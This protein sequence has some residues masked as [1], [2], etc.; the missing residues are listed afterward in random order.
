MAI[1]NSENMRAFDERF[2]C[3]GSVRGNPKTASETASRRPNSTPQNRGVSD[4]AQVAGT[5]AAGAFAVLRI[6]AIERKIAVYASRSAAYVASPSIHPKLDTD[7]RFAIPGSAC[8]S[9]WPT[10]G[11]RGHQPCALLFVHASIGR[12]SHPPPAAQLSSQR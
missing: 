12:E 8:S 1:H 9:R 4:N 5:A 3:Y 10:H 2:D 11:R 6:G 7:F